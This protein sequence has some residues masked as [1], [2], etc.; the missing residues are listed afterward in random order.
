MKQFESFSLTFCNVY[1][2]DHPWRS[3]IAYKCS[4]IILIALEEEE[5]PGQPHAF[6]RIIV[7]MEFYWHTCIWAIL[8]TCSLLLLWTLCFLLV[9]KPTPACTWFSSGLFQGLHTL[10]PL[11]IA[12]MPH[13]NVYIQLYVRIIVVVN[14]LLEARAVLYKLT[15]K[16]SR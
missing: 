2:H 7:F 9:S 6:M 15:C 5:S 14:Q 1:V 13:L 12:K 3:L 8:C 4:H 11:D 10:Q 16:T